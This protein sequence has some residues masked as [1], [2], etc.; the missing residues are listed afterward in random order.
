MP[1]L[2]KR[3]NGIQRQA[4]GFEMILLPFRQDIRRAK[5]FV[6]EVRADDVTALL[7]NCL[8]PSFAN[9]LLPPQSVAEAL[10]QDELV[11]SASMDLVL[12][13]GLPCRASLPSS[14]PNPNP[15][16]DDEPAR[17]FDYTDIESPAL[18]RFYSVLQVRSNPLC[19]L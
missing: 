10:K 8:S 5:T 4:A 11:Q 7:S 1:Q 6:P 2:E 16:P 12:S 15:N 3:E 9:A 13:L 17:L 14:N 18:Q 19:P